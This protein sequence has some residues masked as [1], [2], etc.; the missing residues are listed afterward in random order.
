MQG[1][2]VAFAIVLR[3]FLDQAAS[4]PAIKQGTC[5]AAKDAYKARSLSFF[6]S[7]HYL[8]LVLQANTLA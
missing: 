4:A 3:N 8:M 5:G 1:Y 7:V 6:L 2:T